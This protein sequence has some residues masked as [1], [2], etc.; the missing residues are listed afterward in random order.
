MDRLAQL[1]PGDVA[2]VALPEL[3][4][5]TSVVAMGSLSVVLTLL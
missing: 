4:L 5:V 3:L 2:L 1:G